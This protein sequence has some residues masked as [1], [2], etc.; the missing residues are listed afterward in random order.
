M[1][2]EERVFNIAFPEHNII[3]CCDKTL[4]E[5][6]PLKKSKSKFV[7]FVGFKGEG[8]AFIMLYTRH[9]HFPH[10]YLSFSLLIIFL[11]SIPHEEG[12]R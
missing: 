7:R 5:E 2:D 12:S 8:L 11:F 10:S 1:N 3:L 6:V 4:R 9:M